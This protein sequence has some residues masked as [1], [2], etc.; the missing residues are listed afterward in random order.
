MNQLSTSVAA[1]VN[2]VTEA[3]NVI[4]AVN[5]EYCPDHNWKHHVS[6]WMSGSGKMIDVGIS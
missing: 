5:R 1:A 3:A 6:P 4:D 2:L